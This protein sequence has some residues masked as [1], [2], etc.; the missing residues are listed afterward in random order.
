MAWS[1]HISRNGVSGLQGPHT[2][3]RSKKYIQVRDRVSKS[4]LTPLFQ[5]GGPAPPPLAKGGRGDFSLPDLG[6]MFPL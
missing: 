4:P 1:S 2:K 5:R 6:H 3:L